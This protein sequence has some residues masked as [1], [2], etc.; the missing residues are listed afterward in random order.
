MRRFRTRAACLLVCGAVLWGEGAASAADS[1]KIEERIR[2]RAGKFRGILGIAA[3]DLKG[4]PAI[5]Y[6]GDVRFPTASLIK[7]AVMVETYHQMA[8]GRLRREKVLPLAEADKAGDE[9]V[10]LN[11]LHPGIPL[12][13]PDLLNL[14]I[15]YSDNTATNL[16]VREVGAGRTDRRM[17]AYGLKNTKIFRP[18]F[19]DGHADVYPDLE[20]EFGLG[21]TTPREAAR[22]LALIAEGKIVSRAACDEMLANLSRQQDRQMIPRSL[23]FEKEKIFVANKTGWDEEKLPDASGR[24]GEIRTDAA[25]VRGPHSRYAI[26]ICTRRGK[27]RRP[28]ADNDALVTGAALSRMIYDELEHRA[29]SRTPTPPVR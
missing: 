19:R 24:K 20:R 28:G 4:G 13:I 27:D 7:V 10:V 29:G 22:L 6:N 14:M 9:A 11:Q 15:A 3:I 2:V 25:Y 1:A 18:T 23:P 16:L 21:M 12:T 17:E 26:A 8:E 5:S